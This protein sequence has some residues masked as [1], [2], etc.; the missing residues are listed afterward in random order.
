MTVESVQLS[1]NNKRKEVRYLGNYSKAQQT[2]EELQVEY[3][4]ST[5]LLI[6]H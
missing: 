6:Y 5:F 1:I 2:I 3:R 4:L